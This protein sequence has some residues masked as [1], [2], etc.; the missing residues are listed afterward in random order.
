MP[1]QILVSNICAVP[2]TEW[3]VLVDGEHLW[4]KNE[5]MQSWIDSGGTIESW[6]RSF[7]LVIITDRVL[8]E[9]QWFTDMLIEDIDGTLTATENKYHF[10]QPDPE[11]L[12]FQELY[13]TGQ[14]S[15][16]YAE[17]EPFIVERV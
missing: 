2:K 4:T 14:V 12:F 8:E 1:C 3:I 7:S 15:V 17:V 6:G 10:V 9:M 5:T 11:S 13:F 16:T